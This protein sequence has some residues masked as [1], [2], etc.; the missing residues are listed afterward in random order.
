[1]WYRGSII[2]PASTARAA[3]VAVELEVSQGTISLF[4]R[5]FP[6]GCAGQVSLQVFSQTRQVLPTTP[7]QAY[8][9]DGSEVLGDASIEL[10]EP[11]YVLELR[12][13]S[14]GTTYEHTIYVE[15]YIEKAVDLMPVP[16]ESRVLP[17]GL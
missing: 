12:A 14:P 8:V 11:P 16:L 7:G 3:P 17:L 15:F 9:G 5:L 10:D 4:Y 6:K 13:W 2:V 1:M